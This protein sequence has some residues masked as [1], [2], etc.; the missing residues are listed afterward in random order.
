MA[1]KQFSFQNIQKA[2]KKFRT[3]MKQGYTVTMSYKGKKNPV[4][5]KTETAYI[6]KAWD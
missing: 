2:N 4:T 3:L 1:T 6:I 5:G